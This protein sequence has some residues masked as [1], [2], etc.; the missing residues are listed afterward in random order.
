MKKP[1][2]ISIVFWSASLFGLPQ[3]PILQS[4]DAQFIHSSDVLEIAVSDTTIIHWNQFSIESKELVRFL[5]PGTD[6]TVLNRVLE[7]QPS[8]ILGR[9]ESNGQV[10]LINPNGILVG[11]EAQIDTGSFMASTLDIQDRDFLENDVWTFSGDSPSS[12][13]IE[14]KIKAAGGVLALISG[15][16]ENWVD[17]SISGSTIKLLGERVG[18]GDHAIIDA[19]GT[20]GGG[21]IFIG[22]GFQGKD[23]P[24]AK[25]T[26]V[27]SLAKISADALEQGNGGRI[28]VWG[29][30]ANYFYGTL[31]AKGGLSGGNGGFVEVSSPGYI[32]FQGTVSTF[33]PQGL[34]GT[35]LLDPTQITIGPVAAPQALSGVCGFPVNTFAL[36]AAATGNLAIAT[37]LAAMI[38]SNVTVDTHNGTCGPFAGTGDIILSNALTFTA[39]QTGNLTLNA[40]RNINLNAAIVNNSATTGLICTAAGSVN[41]NSPITYN[42]STSGVLS[43][44]G[45][46]ITIGSAITI[47]AIGTPNTTVTTLTSSS[48]ITVNL[49]ANILN[50][51][52]GNVILIAPTGGTITIHAGVGSLNGSTFVGDP[53][54]P[55]CARSR[56]T[57]NLTGAGTSQIGFLAPNPPNPPA[58]VTGPIDVTCGTLTLQTAAGADPTAKI[59]HGPNT[60]G[61]STIMTTTPSATITVDVLGDILLDNAFPITAQVV[62]GH[63]AVNLDPASSLMG[64][65]CVAA[66]GKITLNN[67][68]VSAGAGQFP[69]THIGHGSSHLQ[70]AMTLINANVTVTAG[71]DITLN[72]QNN[73]LQPNPNPV[74]IGHY[75]LQT[76]TSG[77]GNISVYSG[78][79]VNINVGANNCLATIGFAKGGLQSWAGNIVVSA[80][81]DLRI[82]M[83]PAVVNTIPSGIWALVNLAGGSLTGDVQVAVG[84]SLLY[85]PAGTPAPT[86]QSAGFFIG[87]RCILCA[88]QTSNTYIAVGGNLTMDSNLSGGFSSPYFVEA[89]NDLFIGVQGSASFL[90]GLNAF[91]NFVSSRNAASGVTNIFAGGPI[92]STNAVSFATSG[93]SID[94]RAGG[95]LTIANAL[96]AAGNGFVIA[97]AGFLFSPGMIYTVNSIQLL[98]VANSAL[99][100]P[101]TPFAS[102]CVGCFPRIFGLSGSST[103]NPCQAGSLSIPSIT[104]TTGAITLASGTTAQPNPC[105]FIGSPLILGP[106]G[107][108]TIS[109][110][111]GNITITGFSSISNPFQNITTSNPGSI[112]LSSCGNLTLTNPVTVTSGPGSIS[113]TADSN[114]ACNGNLTI[115]AAVH[116]SGGNISLTSGRNF[117]CHTCANGSSSIFANF[118]VTTTGA[119]TIVANAANNITLASIFQTGTGII[120]TQAGNNTTVNGGSLLT[121]GEI[122]MITGASMTLAKA[123][124][125]SSNSLVTLVID[126]C[127]PNSPLIG[128]ATFTMDGASAINTGKNQPIQIYSTRQL[129]TNIDPLAQFN[130]TPIGNFKG[131]LYNDT[132]SEQWCT[133]FNQQFP[134]QNPPQAPFTLGHPFTIYYKDCLQQAVT[135]AMVIVTQFNVNLHPYNEFPGWLE[136]FWITDKT[137]SVS[138]DQR[139]YFLR[140]RHL[141]L[142]NHPKTYTILNIFFD[143]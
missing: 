89:Q 140:R 131:P 134:Y 99:Y 37:I 52:G 56:P 27:S 94:V 51:D 141:N 71:G 110:T 75:I 97:D 6:S 84:G 31:S 35:L 24:A 3:G 29:D 91:P 70:G 138:P 82:T 59:G 137:D 95:N 62:I 50:N 79:S 85:N 23:L 18:L 102:A 81:R 47:G 36:N 136:R 100:G 76:L 103:T 7:A 119:G 21:E 57:L 135:Q 108:T 5:Q 9:L 19:S 132:T 77:I 39:A 8:R 69:I 117:N 28:I 86:I 126:N 49:N 104:T 83:T 38:G 13:V 10:L 120:F 121:A 12:I 4:G 40:A 129:L 11:K 111:S 60:V 26:Y 74:H 68:E 73:G 43:L 25:E 122:R 48:N 143:E 80:V 101:I 125:S 64:D 61:G 88:A 17:G 128:T 127:N 34:I 30:E 130:G 15:R 67:T 92:T 116:A 93:H 58:I 66:S 20:N 78:G 46:G 42:G 98:T 113:L 96:T 41:V 16:G 133:Y 124:I 53:N 44:T 1:L 142:I 112:L 54:L 118:P 109:T 87:N 33:A 115:N 139:P 22:G 72:S 45:N 14:G 107:N 106:T 105:C 2:P 32:D 63:G 90:G 55:R 65:V 123:T 114:G